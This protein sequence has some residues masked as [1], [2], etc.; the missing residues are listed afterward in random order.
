MGTL[1]TS[2]MPFSWQYVPRNKEKPCCSFF[3]VSFIGLLLAPPA[4]CQHLWKDQC[5]QFLSHPFFAEEVEAFIL[6]KPDLQCSIIKMQYYKEKQCSSFRIWN[7]FCHF[8]FCFPMQLSFLWLIKEKPR[9]R[10]FFFFFGNK[11]PAWDLSQMQFYRFIITKQNQL[12]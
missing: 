11:A 1:V 9:S 7:K 6:W 3:R 4:T 2:S 8:V 12:D 10:N 5:L